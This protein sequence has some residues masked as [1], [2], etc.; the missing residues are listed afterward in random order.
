MTPSTSRS[1]WIEQSLPSPSADPGAWVV[2]T[3]LAGDY[4]IQFVRPREPDRLLDDAAV[5]AQSRRDDYMPYWAYVWPG[6]VLMAEWIAL[7]PAPWKGCVLELGCGL[8]L[9]GLMAMARGSHVTFSDYSTA[10]LHVAGHNARLNGFSRFALQAVD[11][12]CPPAD[13][14]DVILGADI[15]YESRCLPQVLDVLDVMLGRAG[16]ALLSDPG[17]SVAEPFAALAQSR[18]YRVE[19][20]TAETGSPLAVPRRGTIYRLNRFR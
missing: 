7:D 15:L 1:D 5:L 18:G 3:L 8:G 19:L 20:E 13:S 17:R 11:W 6:A 16:V 2:D 12:R 4:R 9:A 14:F 10:A